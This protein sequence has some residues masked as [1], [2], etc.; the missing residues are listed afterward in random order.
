MSW[1]KRECG[2][3]LQLAFRQ[4]ANHS[5]LRFR[6]SKR[7]TSGFFGRTIL[8]GVPIGVGASSRPE[9]SPLRQNCAW[10][11]LLG[12]TADRTFASVLPA[13]GTERLDIRSIGDM[14][15]VG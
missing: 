6:L 10:Q 13:N 7:A 2:A 14:R 12:R 5:A 3:S 15:S 4:H 1:L 9:G 11:P 8:P